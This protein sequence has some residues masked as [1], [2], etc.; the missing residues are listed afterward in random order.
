MQGSVIA[1]LANHYNGGDEDEDEDLSIHSLTPKQRETGNMLLRI[2][3]FKDSY[4]PAD[5][6]LDGACAGDA[7]VS[8]P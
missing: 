3:I 2:L 7:S 6:G 5:W 8:L 1:N 4:V